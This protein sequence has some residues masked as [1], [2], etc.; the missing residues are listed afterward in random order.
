MIRMTPLRLGLFGA[1]NIGGQFNAALAGSE[2][3]VVDAIARRDADKAA[4]CA[5]ENGVPRCHDSCEALP[6]DRETDAI[7]LPLPDNLHAG[8][9][10]RALEA[11]PHVLCEKPL[12]PDVAEAASMVDTARR[13]GRLLAEACAGLAQPQ[14]ARLRAL[15]AEGPI[16]TVRQIAVSVSAF[17]S[18]PDNIRLR[19]ENG[20]G[21]RLDLGRDCVS[22]LRIVAGAGATS[23]T[24]SADWAEAG[25]DRIMV[26]TSAFADGLTAMLNCSF[27]ASCQ[28]QAV[29]HGSEG[30][31]VATFRNH[32]PGPDAEPMPLWRGGALTTRPAEIA[33]PGGRGFLAEAEAEAVRLDPQHRA[34]AFETESLDIARM[35]EASAAIARSGTAITLS[36]T[37]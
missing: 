15:L 12:A 37:G 18:D 19:P 31:L 34:G 11:G 26:A 7:Y 16:G 3:V 30:S 36:A 1:T 29:I 25:V 9:A 28:R 21:A 23:V 24:A 32:A 10:M 2:K 33:S 27:L 17:F 14:T 5:C 35:M 8:S 13:T 22:L 6:A 20:G 4:A